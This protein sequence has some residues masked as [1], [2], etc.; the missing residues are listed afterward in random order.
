MDTAAGLGSVRR[1][2]RRGRTR[3]GREKNYRHRVKWDL[4]DFKEDR[5]LL[6]V[7]NY[8]Q[9]RLIKMESRDLSTFPFCSP[10]RRV[11]HGFMISSGL[12]GHFLLFFPRCFDDT[13]SLLGHFITPFFHR[14][15]SLFLPLSHLF[16]SANVSINYSK[17][18]R[19]KVRN[20]P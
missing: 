9:T 15:F 10:P 18:C 20:L 2:R 19:R 5:A 3:R 1:K 4:T 17:Q 8:E 11:V 7:E 6:G 14:Y 13:L 12:R 16:F